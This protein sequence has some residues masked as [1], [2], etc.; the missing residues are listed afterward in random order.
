MLVLEHVVAEQ[1]SEEVTK[2]NLGPYRID[3]ALEKRQ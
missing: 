3:L 1:K 2:K